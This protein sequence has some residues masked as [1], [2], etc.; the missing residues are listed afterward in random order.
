MNG[1]ER[2]QDHEQHEDDQAQPGL[3]PG[4]V[5]EFAKPDHEDE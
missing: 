2:K 4:P 1:N 5:E 3:P